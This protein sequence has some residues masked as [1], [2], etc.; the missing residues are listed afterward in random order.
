MRWTLLMILSVTFAVILASCGQ[1][2]PPQTSSE[3]QEHPVQPTPHVPAT[4]HSEGSG[5]AEAPTKSDT[6]DAAKS[7]DAAAPTKETS[8]MSQDRALPKTNEEWRKALTQE[9]YYV[10]RQKGT[11]RPF[12]GAFWDNHKAGMYRCVCCGQDLFSSE[13]KFDSGTGW[14]SYFKPAKDGAVKEIEDRTHGMTRTEVTCSKCGAHLG[15][16]FDDGPEPTGLR[17]CINS[18]SLTFEA[19]D[20]KKK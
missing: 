17:Y 5:S 15:H 10:T 6:A 9:Q 11:E 1:A 3:P 12:T 20:E 14:P 7:T 18:V 8:A 16:V 2:K 13:T 19:K 4:V